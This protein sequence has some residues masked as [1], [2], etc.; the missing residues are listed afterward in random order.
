ME[1]CDFSIHKQSDFHLAIT[2]TIELTKQIPEFNCLSYDEYDG[3]KE[4]FNES[5]KIANKQLKKYQFVCIEATMESV[6]ALFDDLELSKVLS[7]TLTLNDQTLMILENNIP[8]NSS[9]FYA[10]NYY[11]TKE[12]IVAILRMDLLT[13]RVKS[14]MNEYEY[15]VS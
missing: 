12:P 11:H 6:T 9:L 10:D 8:F 15:E 3:T 5:W 13:K 1:L 14:M 2:Q 4:S 7:F